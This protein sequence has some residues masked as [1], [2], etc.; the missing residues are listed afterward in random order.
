MARM[1]SVALAAIV[2]TQ[3]ATAAEIGAVAAVN[4]LTLGEPPAATARQLRIADRVVRN[5]RI[6]SEADGGAQIL[7]ADQTTLTIGP[8][9][10]IVLDEYVYDPDRGVGEMSMT[11]IKGAM[12]FIGGRI[13]K[14]TEATI[15]IGGALV[16]L[17][18]AIANVTGDEAS[19]GVTFLAGQYARVAVGDEELSV[20][21]PGG[22]VTIDL[23]GAMDQR[24]VYDGV[25][26]IAS[27]AQQF[28]ATASRGSGGARAGLVGTPAG[29]DS[30]AQERGAPTRVAISTSGELSVTDIL[31]PSRLAELDNAQIVQSTIYSDIANVDTINMDFVDV[32]GSGLLRGQLVWRDSSDLDLYLNLPDGQTVAYFNTTVVFNDGLAIAALDADNLGG[33]INIGPDLRVE[34]IT[35]NPTSEGGS[36]PSGR[37]V[38]SVDAFSVPDGASTPFDLTVTSDS[39]VTTQS[40]SESLVDEQRSSPITVTIGE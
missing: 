21:R 15:Q 33:V 36:L 30:L 23:T 31:P 7:L 5:E 38:F 6:V 34:N 11:F 3:A 28:R 26:D 13:T 9:T 29:G 10:E 14:D 37:Y 18:G 27:V 25:A 19:A 24:I 22:S 8:N 20:S 32:G 39:G 40:L 4:P 1:L 16:G 17:R 35:V 2:A 12:R